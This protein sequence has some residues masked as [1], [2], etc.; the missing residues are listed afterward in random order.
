MN[1][2]EETLQR[3]NEKGGWGWGEGEGRR[4]EELGI[5]GRK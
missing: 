1:R 2:K 4:E 5:K 3:K